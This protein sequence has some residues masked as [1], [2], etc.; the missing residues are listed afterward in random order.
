VASVGRKEV[1]NTLAVIVT[2]NRC[3]LLGR[4]I[5]HLQRQ[6]CAPDEILV[7]NNACTDGTVA[8]LEQRGVHF[9]TQKNV[10]SAG[11]WYRGIQHALEHGFEA[12]WLMDDDGFPDA[13]ALAALE[14]ALVPGVACASSVVVR[15]NEP[16]RFVFPFPVLDAAGLPVIWGSPR[17]LPTVASLKA[18]AP[19]GTYPFAHLFNGAL[20]SIAAVRQAGN[21]NRDYF[22]YGDEVDYFFRLR[23]VGLVISVLGAVH[24]HPDVSKRPYNPVKVYYYFKNSLVLNARYF[25]FVW[26][27]HAMLLTIVLYRMAAR[28]GMGFLISLLVGKQAPAFYSAIVRGLQGKIGKDF[29]G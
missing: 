28:N 3:E 4:C 22:I 11:G 26:T 19:S 20:V 12:V 13:G 5:D 18:V 2:Y 1:L 29:N 9:I 14:A 6:I 21:V 8:M 10:G 23:K 15:E 16:T 7:I 27:R 17:K 25:N 24:Y